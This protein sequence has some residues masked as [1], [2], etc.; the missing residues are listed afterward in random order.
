[1]LG[2]PQNH[3][4]DWRKEHEAKFLGK[5]PQTTLQAWP[6][7]LTTIVPESALMAT[8]AAVSMVWLLRRELQPPSPKLAALST[9]HSNRT[10]ARDRI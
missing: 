10:K 1:M 2:I 3:W 5:T 4:E 7:E 6:D 9:G 8:A